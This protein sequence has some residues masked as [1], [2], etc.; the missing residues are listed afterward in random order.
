MAPWALL[1]VMVL[2][3]YASG[4]AVAGWA[5]QQADRGER[6]SL[7][8]SGIALVVREACARMLLWA[9]TPLG[10]V[11]RAP[12][13]TEY[14]QAPKHAAPLLLVSANRWT[15]SSLIFLTT[16]LRRRGWS[17]VWAVDTRGARTLADRAER[18]AERLQALRTRSGSERV[19]IVAFS[20]GGLAVAWALRHDPTAASAVR[21]LVTVATPWRGTKMAAF[22]RS[23]PMQEIRFGSPVLDGLWPDATE[24][25]CIWS[26]DDVLVIP[27]HSAAPAGPAADVCIEAAGH[28]ELLTS[29]RAY[30]AVQA[31]LERA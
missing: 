3:A 20:T 8:A 19:D 4:T 11:G 6:A 5:L 24:V 30:R 14:R 31:A 7:H 21:R 17:W 9:L 29:P 25:V 15:R 2:L 1:A 10:W 22:S 13:R 28:L 23:M 16:F 18:V 12:R 26:R 27:A